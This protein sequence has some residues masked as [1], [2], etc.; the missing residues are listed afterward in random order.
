MRQ[1]LA[2]MIFWNIKYR[3][4]C[5]NWNLRS[6]STMP[7]LE[8]EWVWSMVN[9][10]L[11]D[12]AHRAIVIATLQ[13][14]VKPS[15]PLHLTISIHNSNCSCSMMRMWKSSEGKR[16]VGARITEGVTKIQVNEV[17]VTVPL[18][19]ATSA[20]KTS[21]PLVLHLPQQT[22]ALGKRRRTTSRSLSRC[23]RASATAADWSLRVASAPPKWKS[24][25]QDQRWKLSESDG[26]W[27][28]MEDG[29]GRE[30]FGTSDLAYV[31]MALYAV[32]ALNRV[33]FAG[34]WSCHSHLLIGDV[35]DLLW[36]HLA[37]SS[38]K[39]DSQIEWMKQIIWKIVSTS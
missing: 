4:G 7:M 15:C 34:A 6:R 9:A 14:K 25:A 27:D 31:C 30:M 32:V 20:L 21:K 38:L 33:S 5:T 18:K 29:I 1:V 19:N 28:G 23:V 26:W 16:E 8:R 39:R 22:Q 17:T 11:R 24:D 2:A 35:I 37:F 10:S 3:W 36:L 12:P 13:L